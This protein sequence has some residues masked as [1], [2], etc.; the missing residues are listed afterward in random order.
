MLAVSSPDQ[1]TAEWLTATLHQAGLEGAV[2]DL[3][4]RSIGAGQVGENAR[5]T[6]AVEGAFP[7]SLVGKFPSQ[8][9]I[10]RQTGIQLQNY[11]RECFFYS[12][13]A[14][15]VDIRTP[16]VFAVAFDPETHDFVLLME[17]LAPG[18]QIDQMSECS[19]D[20]AALALEELAKLHGP[21][22]GDQSLA[23]HPLL[24]R[25][26]PKKGE[27][28]IYCAL[29]QGFLQRYGERLSARERTA[30]AQ[31]GAAQDAYFTQDG[32][33]TLIHID[34]RLDN[35]IFGGPHPLTVLD[36]QSVS[37]GCALNDV[38]Y[39]MGTS[40]ASAQ[41]AAAERDL[42][43][44]YLSALRAYGPA[45]DWSTCWRLY[46][47]HAPA[48]L[49]MAVVASMIVGET[50]RGNDM[51]MTMAKRS[52]AMCEDLEVLLGATDGPGSPAK[53]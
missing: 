41:R 38:S 12:T 18:V 33:H 5:F 50:P 2:R 34:Y 16:T 27:P 39:F 17:D 30:V 22:W 37:M 24:A 13:L 36:W 51:F 8:D 1:V 15:G 48:G 26:A 45:P 49:H 21:R 23:G 52:I 14:A 35:M 46:R 44:H 9:P 40:L 20:Q 4:W 42:L 3:D 32:P 11:A 25:Q 28:H 43:K 6:L 7:T 19:T 47:R 29:Q 10:S 53:A 31:F